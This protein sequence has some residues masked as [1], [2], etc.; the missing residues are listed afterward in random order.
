MAS[1]KDIIPGG[2]NASEVKP[3][4]SRGDSS[5]LPR[6]MYGSEISNAET[7]Q[8]NNKTGHLLI[9]EHSF[10]EPDEFSRRRYWQRINLTHSTSPE[11][12]RIGRE[13]LSALCAAVGIKGELDDTDDLIG[14]KLNLR[15]GQ[16]KRKDNGEMEN[17]VT[18]M[19][20]VGLSA[21]AVSKP[22]PTAAAKKPWQK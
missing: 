13:E 7:K 4:E 16:K 6:G 12:E 2:F 20:P 9:V 5:L 3:S 10:Y 8:N 17:N 22:A 18:G 21:P 14:R 1:L 15:L 11:A 19:E